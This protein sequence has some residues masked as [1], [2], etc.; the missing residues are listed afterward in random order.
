MIGI[1]GAMD[2]EVN[3]LKAEMDVEKIEKKAWQYLLNMIF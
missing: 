1:I 3:I 2:Q